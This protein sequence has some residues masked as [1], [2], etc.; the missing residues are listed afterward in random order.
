[1]KTDV[2][3]IHKFNTLNSFTLSRCLKDKLNKMKMQ[4][5]PQI[6]KREGFRVITWLGQRKSAILY[7]YLILGIVV[8]A[9]LEDEVLQFASAAGSRIYRG[10]LDTYI[11]LYYPYM[12]IDAVLY[13]FQ[14]QICWPCL[15]RQVYCV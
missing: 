1:M 4:S 3:S 7:Y 11:Y 15:P 9:I 8:L 12:S 2:I 5:V 14:L 6:I 10:K 13:E